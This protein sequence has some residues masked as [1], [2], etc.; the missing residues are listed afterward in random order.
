MRHL[1][2]APELTSSSRST[3]RHPLARGVH[4][5]TWATIPPGSPNSFAFLSLGLQVPPG[6]PSLW[7][8]LQ[9]SVSGQGEKRQK[10]R[11]LRAEAAA[12]CP[13]PTCK[14]NCKKAKPE[15][16]VRSPMGRLHGCCQ[17]ATRVVLLGPCSLLQP[18]LQCH[19]QFGHSWLAD[20]A[21]IFVHLSPVAFHLYL[22]PHVSFE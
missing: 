6:C 18:F 17:D 16:A 13:S 2:A 15:L 3:S 21:L 5:Q 10:N 9:T 12:C 22:C 20:T 19:W 7:Q 8:E 1:C 14:S 11:T 4:H